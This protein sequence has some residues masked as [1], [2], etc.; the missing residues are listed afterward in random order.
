[1]GAFW[2]LRWVRTLGYIVAGFWVLVSLFTIVLWLARPSPHTPTA[3]EAAEV[4]RVFGGD[5]EPGLWRMEY[6]EPYITSQYVT[7]DDGVDIAVDIYLPEG[8]SLADPEERLPAI[9][10][11]T[12]YWRRWEL[13]PLF[14]MFRGHGW[15]QRNLV[16][17]GYAL[18]YMDVRGS[19]ASFGTRPHPWSAREVADFGQVLDWMAAQP[20]CDGNLA[21]MGVSYVGTAAEFAATTGRQALKCIIP[22]FSLYDVYADI[23]YP[24]GVFNEWF[25]WRWGEFNQSLDAGKVPESVGAF[26]HMAVRGVPAAV[27]GYQGLA[28]KEAAF[29]EHKANVNVYKAAKGVDFRD[30]PSPLNNAAT[31]DFSPHTRQ[32]AMARWLKG[33]GA[34]WG[35]SG[36]YDGAY[37]RSA[38]TRFATLDALAPGAQRAVI[39]PWNHGGARHVS[40]YKRFD[41]D[42]DPAMDIQMYALIRYLNH[43]LKGM[44]GLPEPGV[45]YHTMGEREGV[46]PWKFSPVWPP[47]GFTEEVWRL[48][49]QGL[50]SRT[51]SAG[52]VVDYAVDYQAGSGHKNRWRTQLGRSDVE[53]GNR[54]DEDARLLV[55]ETEPLT[56]DLEVTGTPVVRLR[57]AS[58]HEDGAVFCYLED[59]EEGAALPGQASG[60]LVRYV[61]EGQLRLIHRQ[62][63]EDPPYAVFGPHHDFRQDSARPMP[64]G[65][66]QDLAISL[67]PVSAL[68]KKGHRIRLAIA[69]A[70]R[71]QFAR[72]P[73]DPAA[74]DPVLSIAL[75]GS[76]IA[77]PARV[78]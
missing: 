67:E 34:V 20:W 63:A 50:L 72:Y 7:M 27:E 13:H 56:R 22:R 74:G 60:T 66:F 32:E 45:R 33:G 35:W 4:A 57:L 69:G 1:M 55:F 78:R 11:P 77:L 18:V 8:M 5:P 41:A 42:T 30:E 12:R 73:E 75:D 61:T 2:K 26:A 3:E 64:P 54:A 21:A 53:Y 68:F 10:L 38:L 37:A 29:A 76:S 17:S 6:D 23:A 44:G 9:L 40:Q 48:G 25:V 28:L 51:A 15:L 43:H 36:W 65:V 58:T 19:G 70:D 47:L 46:E 24:G 59:V 14:A 71:H 49:P 62:L 16:R 31:D 39:G 52:G